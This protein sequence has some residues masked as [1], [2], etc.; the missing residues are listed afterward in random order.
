MIKNIAKVLQDSNVIAFHYDNR[1]WSVKDI[2]DR[3]WDP[4]YK[5]KS[6]SYIK[7]LKDFLEMPYIEDI[8]NGDDRARDTWVHG[9]SRMGKNTNLTYSDLRDVNIF[10][11]S[12]LN[13]IYFFE[14]LLLK[15]YV[16]QNLDILVKYESEFSKLLPYR[17]ESDQICEVNREEY[18]TM[19]FEEKRSHVYKIKE[20][21]FGFLNCLALE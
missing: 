13:G 5:K 10:R 4:K 6:I 8:F 9:L 11:I 7:G 21:V 15:W 20:N 12:K 18:D 14:D 3:L 1:D 2:D 16:G 17:C 19:K